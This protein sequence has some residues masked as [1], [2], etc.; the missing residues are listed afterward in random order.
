MR[1]VLSS[2]NRGAFERLCAVGTLRSYLPRTVVATSSDL[3]CMTFGIVNGTAKVCLVSPEGEERA[4]HYVKN[5]FLFGISGALYGRR[6]RDIDLLLK[7]VTPCQILLLPAQRLRQIVGEDREVLEYC[8]DLMSQ[9][10]TG[11]IALLY[12]SSFGDTLRQTAR[13]LNSLP[14]VDSDEGQPADRYIVITQEEL[15][16]LLAKTRVTV[17]S[18]LQRLE[19]LGAIRLGHRSRIQIVDRT[20]LEDIAAL[21]S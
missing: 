15:A 7:T 2:S 18:C 12:A 3:G 21:E 1:L 16:S 13:V 17:G 4:L 20:I 11:L 8:L 14:V 6:H 19:Q 5:G 9:V 10:L